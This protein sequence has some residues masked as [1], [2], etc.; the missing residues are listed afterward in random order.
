MTIGKKLMLGFAALFLIA[1]SLGGAYVYSVGSLAGEFKTATD[2]T[3]KKMFLVDE[4]QA[5]FF[6]LRSCQRGVML[7]ALHKL[8]EKVRSNKEEFETRAAAVETLFAE[9]KPLLV[10]EHGRKRCFLTRNRVSKLQ[11][12]L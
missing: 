9:M 10:T 12:L 1:V 3:A 2:V 8:P 11:R 4:I 5:E 6:R 7:F